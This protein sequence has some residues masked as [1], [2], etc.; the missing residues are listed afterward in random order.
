[1]KRRAPA[2]ERRDDRYLPLR[3]F[4]GKSVFLQDLRVGPAL[5][6]IK[7]DDQWRPLFHPDLVHAIF[8]TVQPEQATVGRK[9]NACER[10]EGAVGREIGIGSCGHRGPVAGIIASCYWPLARA[11][12]AST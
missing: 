3:Q 7:L 4:P 11:I 1:M 2:G 8:V 12:S 5:R 6:A 10:V 9:T